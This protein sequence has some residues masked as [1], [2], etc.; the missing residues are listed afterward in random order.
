MDEMDKQF[1][2]TR[3]RLE[4]VADITDPSTELNALAMSENGGVV[5]AGEVA[6]GNN[7][8]TGYIYDAASTA[9]E[10]VP[11]AIDSAGDGMWL[12]AFG[13]YSYW[14][15][16]LPMTTSTNPAGTPTFA[17]V[18]TAIVDAFSGVIITLSA[19]GNSQTIQDPT[20]ATAGKKFWVVADSENGANT[21]DVVYG[22]TS[23]YTVTLS[24][25]EST[26]ALW[27][28]SYWQHGSGVDAND[29]D[30]NPATSWATTT[31]V[32]SAWDEVHTATGLWMGA[33][34]S[35][36]TTGNTNQLYLA[37]GGQNIMG[38]NA[39]IVTASVERLLQV[40]STTGLGI[41]AI[42]WQAG[43]G[44]QN[45]TLGH[46]RNATIG[47]YTT[48]NDNDNL[49]GMQ[50]VGS[51][52]IDL[53]TLGAVIQAR[54]NGTPAANRM[55][56]DLEFYTALG[57]ADNDNA[58]SAKLHKD[59]MLDLY[60]GTISILA[61]ADSNA[62]TRGATSDKYM[63]F[64]MPHYTLTEE[65][66]SILSADSKTG[67][68]RLLIGGGDGTMNA[69]EQIILYTAA[70]DVTLTGTAALTINN[71]ASST[72]GGRV[73]LPYALTEGATTVSDAAYNPSI[74]TDDRHIEFTT[75]TASR[76]VTISNEDIATGS[77]TNPRVISV[78]DRS[79]NCAGGVTITIALE[80]GNL[81]G[82][83]NFVLDSAYE[84][85]T[86]HLD[87]TNGFVR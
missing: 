60:G 48:L 32:Q 44:G 39:S 33:S 10:N 79:G 28:G 19:G 85:A 41:S 31:N 67:V 46:V 49:G 47:T 72:F 24:A 18:T 2:P 3:L 54:V 8:F 63:R 76:I 59:A 69:V 77:P 81:N 37:T 75:L 21:I 80:T 61:G 30:F 7:D 9:T 53:N 86:I 68:S 45:V 62:K 83:A 56:A 58:L 74:L 65:P 17:A 23:A 34:N 36:Y 27:N 1:I 71:D 20:D 5:V 38:H 87:G 4:A 55:P 70:D 29:I 78:G 6:A 57:G 12:A 82:A 84:S 35:I 14:P 64:G 50:F 22:G 16:T 25:G 13:K 42:N 40:H 11:Y 52:G 66:V 51:D 43:A 26:L 73:N 15:Q